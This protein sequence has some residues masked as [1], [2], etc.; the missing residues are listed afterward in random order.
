[1]INTARQLTRSLAGIHHWREIQYERLAGRPSVGGRLGPLTS[2]TELMPAVHSAANPPTAA[3][4]VD[5][6]N[7]QTDGQTDE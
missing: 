2:G 3:A 1:M 6:W 7:R 5:R 4:A